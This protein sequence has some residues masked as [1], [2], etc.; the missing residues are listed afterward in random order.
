MSR[1]YHY[2]VAGLPDIIFDDNK[3]ATD[4]AGFRQM[5]EEHLHPADMEAIRLYYYRFDNENV[6]EQLDNPDATPSPLGNLSPEM[7]QELFSVARE[8]ITEHA[9]IPTYLLRFVSAY[10]ADEPVFEDKSWELQLSE[11][12]YE[13]ICNHKNAFI[14]DWFSFERDMKNIIT[15]VQCRRYDTPV[16]NQIIGKSELA[17]KLI[18]STA[19]DFGIDSDF[20]M[21]E[22]ILKAAEEED[23]KEFEKKLDLIR[24][25]YLD[26]AVFFHF[27]TIEKIFTFVLKLSIV[28]R[29]ISLD[30]ETGQKLLDELLS[31][32][33]AS[34][35]FPEIFKSKK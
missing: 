15:A 33:E 24:W 1:Q 35:E 12:Y 11:L 14:R 8:G 18:R 13:A 28:E 31:D 5:L 23:L 3:L 19:R 21:L 9:D 4:L 22:Q 6:L 17:Q 16:E 7:L 2:L 10:K 29:W 32:L 34:Y 25:D 30:R 27:F 20:P 26:D